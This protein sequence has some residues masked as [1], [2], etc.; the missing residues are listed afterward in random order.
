MKFAVDEEAS[1]CYRVSMRAEVVDLF[2]GIGGLSTG[3]QSEGFKVRA[4]VDVDGTC[5]HAFETNIGAKFVAKGIERLSSAE[6]AKLYTRSARR[7]LVGCAPCQPFSLYTGRYRRNETAEDADRRW[8]LL[9]EFARLIESALPDVVS[10]ENVPRVATHV[11]F[12]TFVARLEAAGYTVAYYKVR[13]QDYGVPQRRTRLVLF[14]SRYGKVKLA[15]PTHAAKPVTVREAIGQLP[16]IAA[17]EAH[18]KD[19]LH[20]SRGLGEMNLCR[21]RATP[22]GGSWKDWDKDLQLDCHK[23]DGGR[24][25]RAV[26]G[27]MSWDEPSPV[28][29]TQCLG[30]GNGRFGHPS[31]DRAI[32][33]REAAILQSFS[34][35]FDFVPEDDEVLGL[36][37][38]RQIGNAVPPRLAQAIARSI[39]LHLEA[40]AP[41]AS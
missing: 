13:A 12:G 7:I 27:R 16:P 26:Y 21:L 2:C 32:S 9:D 19:R 39:K 33:I 1:S 14:A 10:M 36:H 30:I 37:L 34:P 31:Q 17:G 38:A 41:K 20:R 4:G 40:E 25:F 5:R 29:T 11:A 22:E 24:S 28:I 15:A 18:A 6:L 23:K 35:D 8:A 3:F